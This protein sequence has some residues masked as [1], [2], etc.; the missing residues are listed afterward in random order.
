MRCRQPSIP[1][2]APRPCPVRVSGLQTLHS[3][4]EPRKGNGEN[5]RPRSIFPAT[6]GRIPFG[7]SIPA[8][9]GRP[10]VRIPPGNKTFRSL[11][12]AVPA[13][14][15]SAPAQRPGDRPGRRRATPPPYTSSTPSPPPRPDR[16]VRG[17]ARASPEH[18][19][20]HYLGRYR[21]TEYDDIQRHRCDTA[22]Q[23]PRFRAPFP[24]R[25]P[26]GPDARAGGYRSPRA[27]RKFPVPFV[28]TRTPGRRPGSTVLSSDFRRSGRSCSTAKQSATLYPKEIHDTARG[29]V[30]Q[31]RNSVFRKFSR[32][33]EMH[34]RAVYVIG[35]SHFCERSAA[36]PT[37]P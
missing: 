30:S 16:S 5:S 21:P 4:R 11:I 35:R 23:H 37:R 12:C 3:V 7:F 17:R 19:A 8:R 27:A 20:R 34:R 29:I 2:T 36:H 6:A 9:G 24:R 13:D 18:S 22:Q 31:Q 33:R 25:A 28:I 15:C 10:Q 32:T 1:I 26:G 14:R